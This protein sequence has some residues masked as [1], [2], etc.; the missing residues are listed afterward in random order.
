[1]KREALKPMF[2][3]EH[4]IH[5]CTSFLSRSSPSRATRATRREPSWF[6]RKNI[7]DDFY[8]YVSEER[9]R[10]R[11]R[12]SLFSLFSRR[13][14]RPLNFVRFSLSFSSCF[15]LNF[16]CSLEY[17][18]SFLEAKNYK[19]SL[20]LCTSFLSRIFSFLRNPKRCR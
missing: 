17:R 4:L 12:L 1:M 10:S 15:R 7:R 13:L 18:E 14:F 6:L 5:L 8:L 9:V 19:I 11:S 3:L 20:F 16:P 2:S